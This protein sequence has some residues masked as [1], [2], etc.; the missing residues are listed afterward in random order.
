M[1][2]LENNSIVDLEDMI[3]DFL[4][5]FL[6]G[7]ETTANSLSFCILELARNPKIMQ[8]YINIILKNLKKCFY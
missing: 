3:D 1:V 8:K 6:A 7:Q 5:F 2:I 4:T